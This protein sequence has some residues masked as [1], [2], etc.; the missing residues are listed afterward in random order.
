MH[1]VIAMLRHELAAHDKT[2][3]WIDAQRFFKEK[4]DRPQSLRASVFKKISAAGYARVSHLSKREIWS[5]C[6]EIL[7]SDLIHARGFAF[8]WA[9][10]L[11][12]RLAPSDFA[13]LERWL[14]RHVKNWGHCDSLCCGAL[15]LLIRKHPEVADRRESWVR[16]RNRWVRRGAAVSLIPA[17]RRGDLLE[18]ALT[19]AAALLRDSDDMVQKGYGWML[20]DASLAFPKEVFAFV[21]A[22][23]GLMPRTALRYAIERYPNVKRKQAMAR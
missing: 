13:R 8:D 18:D 3:N 22:H 20:K 2:E 23:K 11:E 10:R 4:L 14:G 17:L 9:R 6:E 19:T 7:A 5:V 12:R 1:E 16:S 21:M 15:G